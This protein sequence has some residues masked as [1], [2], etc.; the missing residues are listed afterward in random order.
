MLT[1]CALL[2]GLASVPSGNLPTDNDM[3]RFTEMVMVEEI[4]VPKPQITKTNERKLLCFM[5]YT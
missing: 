2:I 5:D 1:I 4:S 3:I